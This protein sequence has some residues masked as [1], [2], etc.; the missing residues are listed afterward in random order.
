MDYNDIIIISLLVIIIGLVFTKREYI[1]TEQ[2][3]NNI[4]RQYL[5]IST[6]KNL[7]HQIPN[8]YVQLENV[9]K[10]VSINEELNG[11]KKNKNKSSIMM[12]NKKFSNKNYHQDNDSEYGAESLKRIPNHK[13]SKSKYKN[14]ELINKKVIIDD[15]SEFDN[16]KSLNSMD[17]TLSDLISV[18]ENDK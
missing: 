16:I 8:D 12:K 14:N 17:N 18:V 11:M 15:Y 7:N 5:G 13:Y 3:I 1:F 6:R 9:N 10:S 4:P 2:E